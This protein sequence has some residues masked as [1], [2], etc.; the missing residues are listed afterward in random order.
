MKEVLDEN[1]R[2]LR[3]KEAV[4]EKWREYFKN[5]MN[6]TDEGPTVVAAVILSGG[7]GGV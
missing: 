7:R 2:M 3:D 5:F 4:K 1:R 6:F